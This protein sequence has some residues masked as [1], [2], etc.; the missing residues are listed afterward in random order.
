[1]IYFSI[2]KRGKDVVRAHANSGDVGVKMLAAIWENPMDES[3]V[4]VHFKD[5]VYLAKKLAQEGFLK[6]EGGV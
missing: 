4:E 5:G 3:E 6:A 2:T 1:M